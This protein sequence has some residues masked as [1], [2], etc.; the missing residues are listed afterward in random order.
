MGAITGGGV[1]PSKMERSAAISIVFLTF[2]W[3]T[4]CSIAF[5]IVVRENV[6]SQLL[7]ALLENM[8]LSSFIVAVDPVLEGLEVR[9][10]LVV[11]VLHA[12][13]KL[14]PW[15][16]EASIG[17]MHKWYDPRMFD[18]LS[19]EEM[20]LQ[21]PLPPVPVLHQVWRQQVA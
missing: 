4:A 16:G 8:K 7:Q 17:P 1:V 18:V 10:G 12:L 2:F 6:A 15:R 3:A 20:R 14:G 11:R 9:W 5:A 21:Q 13:T 19:E